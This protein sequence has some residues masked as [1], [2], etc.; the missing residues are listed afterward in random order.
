MRLKDIHCLIRK[1]Q[2]AATPEEHIRQNLLSWMIKDQG[3]P[4]EW[5][6][7]EKSLHE[8][9]HLQNFQKD[10]L[11]SRRA[12]IVVFGKSPD[13][14]S[15]YVPIFLIECKAVP[16]TK[17]DF[18][19]VAGYNHFLKAYFIALVNGSE[20]IIAQC[21]QASQGYTSFSQFPSYSQL[22]ELLNQSSM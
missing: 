2:V 3:Y 5:I 10:P 17:Q 6:A 18:G 7:L 16:L 19:Q 1:K 9:A 22:C 11:P 13:C 14:P 15:S 21:N 4:S 12:D 8:M 20:C